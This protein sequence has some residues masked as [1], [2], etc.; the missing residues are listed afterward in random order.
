MPH[1]NDFFIQ[2]TNQGRQFLVVNIFFII[3]LVYFKLI[4]YF[5][6]FISLYVTVLKYYLPVLQAKQD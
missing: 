3:V 4:I 5:N 6:I 2:G 1:S